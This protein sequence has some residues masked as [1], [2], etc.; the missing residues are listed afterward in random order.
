MVNFPIHIRRKSYNGKDPKKIA[1]IQEW[2]EIAGDLEKMINDIVEK[3]VNN[4]QSYTYTEISNNTGYTISTVEELCLSIDG[5]SNG[6][7]VM[8]YDSN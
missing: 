8:R 3:Q 6:F 2:N 5:G 4:I 1:K 7:T